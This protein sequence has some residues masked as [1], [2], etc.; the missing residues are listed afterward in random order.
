M[1]AICSSNTRAKDPAAVASTR[2]RQAA[3][4]RRR[5]SS[6]LASNQV[7]KR[8]VNIE[9]PATFAELARLERVIDRLSDEELERI[10][11]ALACDGRY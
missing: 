10:A 8:E 2:K 6:W 11:S 3:M 9:R 7:E 1:A 4:T 5:L